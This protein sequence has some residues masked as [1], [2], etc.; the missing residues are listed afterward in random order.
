MAGIYQLTPMKNLCLSKCRTPV[1]F[2]MT[3]WRGGMTGAL[4]MGWLHGLYCFGCC[5]LL[6]ALLFPLGMMNVAAMAAITLLI[7]AEK[8]LPWGFWGAR[9]A[10][11]VLIGYGAVV[12][13]IPSLLPHLFRT[14]RNEYG[15]KGHP[16]SRPGAAGF[17]G[18]ATA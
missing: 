18:I 10:A 2:I 1:S 5:W 6:F 11:I 7:F 9:A 12:I 14:A 16:K 15:L 13:A 17:D 3:S 4:Q 8:A